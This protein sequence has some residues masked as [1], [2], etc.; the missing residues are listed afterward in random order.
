MASTGRQTRSRKRKASNSASDT[1]EEITDKY[2][3][4][5]LK[6]KQILENICG[7]SSCT[8]DSSKG[9]Q[10]EK[11]AKQIED[12]T[13][14]Q[15]DNV[16]CQKW[17]QIANSVAQ[18]LSD[19]SQ[20]YCYM[21]SDIPYN[22]C[23]K[24]EQDYTAYDKLAKK[25]GFK[26]VMSHLTEGVLV[27][28]K[29]HGYC[30]QFPASCFE[31][32]VMW[33][34]IVTK[35]PITE[36]C[37][38]VDFEG[39]PTHYHIE[40]LGKN[41]SHAWIAAA[42]ITLYG[43]KEEKSYE[44][45]IKKKK[46]GRKK[47]ILTSQSSGLYKK[48]YKQT[49]V[50]D[51]IQEAESMMDQGVEDRL[52]HITFIPKKSLGE[53]TVE[54][55]TEPTDEFS[56]L[57]E[58]KNIL[59]LTKTPE[60]NKKKSSGR[61]K[62]TKTPLQKEL[63]TSKVKQRVQK[64]VQVQDFASRQVSFE[65]SCI[66][67]TNLQQ[68]KGTNSQKKCTQKVVVKK[69]TDDILS[70]G[71][72]VLA[73]LDGYDK[74]PAVMTRDPHSGLQFE[75]DS[76]NQLSTYH[77]EFLGPSH[78][79]A[80]IKAD[81]V[82]LYSKDNMD[83]SQSQSSEKNQK[84]KFKKKLTSPKNKPS[85]VVLQKLEKSKKEA[86]CMMNLSREQRLTL[87]KFRFFQDNHETEDFQC[88]DSGFESWNYPAS[89]GSSAFSSAEN[90]ACSRLQ[91]NTSLVDRSKEERF[92][93]DVE[94][95]KKNEKAF[96]HDLSRFMKR[97]NLSVN[98]TA[99]WHHIPVGAFQLFL[100]VHERGG[101]QEICRK[102]QWTAV[103]RE[104][105]ETQLAAGPAPKKFYLR[106]I[107]AYELYVTNGDFEAELKRLQSK[108]KKKSVGDVMIED[109]TGS[110]TN[111]DVDEDGDADSD[112]LAAMLADLEEYS[113]L[114]QL[115]EDIEAEKKRMGIN[116]SYHED[117]P[118]TKASPGVKYVSTPSEFDCPTSHGNHHKKQQEVPETMFSVSSE[119]SQNDLVFHQMERIVNEDLL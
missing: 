34:G 26:Y 76:N 114:C 51:A 31:R 68:I 40:Y 111:V 48:K 36:Y 11:L 82:R 23:S 100:A 70:E 56:L 5:I 113:S 55:K 19:E 71:T 85:K 25:L 69:E 103:F 106:N 59:Y 61:K 115:E 66:T 46:R 116:I 47:K 6:N 104:L 13:W 94:M 15:C 38:D 4:D 39:N 37:M 73:K 52:K 117:S 30:R 12:Y 18:E 49:L 35:D 45:K 33:P 91:Y 24:P 92:K 54:I 77:V 99:H 64:S 9:S 88:K 50:D 108:R 57:D 44:T 3:K 83:D 93:L 60:A 84:S 105:T 16:D 112:G 107:Y 7:Q 119:D 95:Y 87:C 109:D 27:W 98:L 65:P 17:R 97:N 72:L 8:D 102:K 42:H 118:Y 58:N 14:V 90:F 21:N 10:Y 43:H 81:R 74:W 2:I 96:L 1:S 101:Y 62:S 80:W 79:H 32:L 20:W 86:D 41:H 110:Y 22:S 63:K 67:S 28:A 29:M 75:L 89:S 53:S 78:T